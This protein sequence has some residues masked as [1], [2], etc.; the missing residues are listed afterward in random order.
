MRRLPLFL[1][2]ALSLSAAPGMA[3]DLLPASELLRSIQSAQQ[4]TTQDT[5]KDV[6]LMRDLSAYRARL[7]S[8]DAKQASEQWISLWDRAAEIKQATLAFDYQSYDPWV[9]AS[10]GPR[11]VLA[12]LP[13]PKAWTTLSAQ[14]EKRHSDDSLPALGLKMLGNILSR[15]QQA[16]E[17]TIKLARERSKDSDPQQRRTMEAQLDSL[18]QVWATLY[19]RP[20]EIADAF[21]R[22]AKQWQ[23]QEYAMALDVPDLV[24]M[25][26]EQDAAKVLLATLQMPVSL[27]APSSHATAQLTRSLALKHVSS[28]QRPQWE[29]INSAEALDLF[30]ALDQRFK[31]AQSTKDSFRFAYSRSAASLWYLV[32]LLQAERHNEAEALLATFEMDQLNYLPQEIVAA[33]EANG[34]LGAFAKMLGGVLEQSASTEGWKSFLQIS[35]AAGRHQDALQ[36]IESKLSSPE[37]GKS[38]RDALNLVRIDALLSA[39]AI[40]QAAELLAKLAVPGKHDAEASTRAFGHAIRLAALG[41]VTERSDWSEAGLQGATALFKAQ[42]ESAAASDQSDLAEQAV[43]LYAETRKQGKPGLAQQLAVAALKQ[44][45]PGE[46]QG[47]EALSAN[48]LHQQA[49]IELSALY[50]EAGQHTDL[51]QLLDEAPTWS[52]RDLGELIES[53]D[54]LGVPLAS[55]VGRALLATGQHD[56]AEQV[57]EEMLKRLPNHDSGYAVWIDILGERAAD[58]LDQR[59]GQDPFQERPLIWKAI[60]LQRSG[61]L[62]KSEQA[63]RAAIAIDPSDGEQGRGDRMR[64]YAV[65]AELLEAQGKAESAAVYRSAVSAIRMSEE[66]DELHRLGL[67]RRAIELYG[68]ALEQFS[69]AYCIQSRLAV[70]LSKQG[71]T[72]EALLHYRRAFE[73]MPDSFGRVESHCFGCE[74]VFQGTQAQSIAEAVFKQIM[75]S[76]PDQPQARYMMAYLRIEQ[77]RFG[78]AL[79]HLRDAVALDPDYLNA[80]RKLHDLGEKSYI[81]AAERDIARLKLAELDPAQRHVEFELHEVGDLRGLWTTLEVAAA[82]LK[83]ETKRSEIYPFTSSANAVRQAIDSMPESMREQYERYM[84]LSQT[85]QGD[86]LGT[87]PAAQMVEHKLLTPLA[88]IA[89]DTAPEWGYH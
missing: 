40:E 6:Q 36:A 61:A 57:I 81:P 45:S 83:H 16:L 7:N 76:N 80:W 56:R 21:L 60:V 72:Q 44:R 1:S 8:L 43:K 20:E 89:G 50:A 5:R 2:I 31:G 38:D 18:Q 12:S 70:Q 28:L 78:E 71:R 23:E 4:D 68:K 63:V 74:S 49:L 14:I 86:R 82:R 66:A 84:E 73:L 64:A 67:H 48:A 27:A 9:R 25:L 35:S 46:H 85:M 17:R 37:L 3:D 42:L 59:Y 53:K 33:L 69:D 22:G 47:F 51:L 32:G 52:A 26:G 87:S 19:G 41:R 13:G 58:A 11:S 29:L 75:Q 34:K 88:I 10:V 55:L 39:D 62:E 15:D 24:G 65:L 77:G 54:S 79:Q 30:E